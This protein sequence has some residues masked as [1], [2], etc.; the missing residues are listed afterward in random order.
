M[1]TNSPSLSASVDKLEDYDE[2]VD[3]DWLDMGNPPQLAVSSSHY[4]PALA[5]TGDDHKVPSLFSQV[6]TRNPG[7]AEPTAVA[8]S[9]TR[10]NEGNEA[11][12]AGGS[13]SSLKVS[14]GDE[15]P[16]H[17][18]QAGSTSPVPSVSDSEYS[19]LEPS[20]EPSRKN[21]LSS[22]AGFQGLTP[23]GMSTCSSPLSRGQDR[24]RDLDGDELSPAGTFSPSFS[25][26]VQVGNDVG[27]ESSG[28]SAQSSN[29]EAP[30]CAS[31]EGRGDPD[32]HDDQESSHPDVPSI[33]DLVEQNDSEG[34]KDS[35]NANVNDDS[36]K[37]ASTAA[38]A[39]T[40]LSSAPPTISPA[41]RAMYRATVEDACSSE[42][43]YETTGLRYRGSQAQQNSRPSVQQ[44]SF[45]TSTAIPTMPGAFTVGPEEVPIF[46]N[47]SSSTAP[48]AATHP[49]VEERQC[50]ICLGGVDDEDMLGRLI[51][52]CLCKG[53]MKYVH[54]ECLNSWR[55]R[56][57]KRE[58]H[59]KCDTCKYSF[60]FRR[61]S[62][63]QFLGHPLT[64]IALT[65]VAFVVLVFIAGFVMKLLLYLTMDEPQEFVYPVDF[66]D[67]DDVEL[68]MQKEGTLVLKTPDSLRAVFRIDKT[69]M[70]FGSFFTSVIGFLQLLTS[71]ILSGGGGGVFRIGG[72]GLGGRRRGVR[73]DRQREAGISGVVLIAMLVFGLFKSIYMTYKLVHRVSSHV[74][75]K[76]EMMVLEVQ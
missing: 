5:R 73:A 51:S 66:D 37:D 23:T 34:S 63:A 38:A 33:P 46:G 10:V 8:A 59:Y 71:I 7:S 54:I 69:H 64:V 41:M 20:A 16:G 32:G 75:A 27:E 2:L 30:T 57:P 62:F 65:L 31:S 48:A 56:S 35:L 40:T 19:L 4:I 50:R 14:I 49:P 52:P 42:D 1:S 61:T 29:N 17:R 60:S 47:A 58:S 45:S 6:D 28:I 18:L 22:L 70:V 11:S 74:L 43:E 26:F 39:S 12:R 24:G 68:L 76:A 25:D 53:S 13:G 3:E 44:P 36:T 15:S 21:S 55:A 9:A 72:F 67:E